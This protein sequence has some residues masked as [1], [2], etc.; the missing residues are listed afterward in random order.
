MERVRLLPVRGD[1][2]HLSATRSTAHWAYGAALQA[3]EHAVF[4]VRTQI[5]IY[6]D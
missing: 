2:G 6:Q 5:F 1:H 4:L 3:E